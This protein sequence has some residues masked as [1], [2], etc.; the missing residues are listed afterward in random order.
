MKVLNTRAELLQLI[1]Q[2]SEIAEIGVFRGQFSEMI[3]K[4]CS[5]KKLHLVDIW[6]GREMSG[7]KDGK[8]IVRITDM[9]EIYENEILAKFGDNPN[10]QIHRCTS[11]NYFEK[12][13][14]NSLD[15]I[16]IDAAHTYRAVK[17]DIENARKVV[18]SGGVIMGHDYNQQKFPGTFKAVN[19]FVAKHELQIEY[20][21]KDGMPSFYIIN[22]K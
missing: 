3:L 21:T 17:R 5:P 12:T 9:Q 16:Y 20:I 14:E 10:V 6:E 15:A 11:D 22:N 4:E 18:R 1:N 19:E 13:P 7:D 8:N 2:S